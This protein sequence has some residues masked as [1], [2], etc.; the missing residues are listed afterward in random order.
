MTPPG[1]ASSGGIA[2]TTFAMRL[3]RIILRVANMERSKRFWV[4][5]VGLRIKGSSGE[6]LFLDGGSVDLILSHDE[7]DPG[8][9]LTEIVFETED[10]MSVY[11]SLR[12]RGVEFIVE[13]RPVMAEGARELLAAHFRDPDGHLASITGWRDRS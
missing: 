6:F 9:S 4:D 2:E 3:S 8:H 13:P 1:D 10:V 7:A 12:Q 11:E 5:S